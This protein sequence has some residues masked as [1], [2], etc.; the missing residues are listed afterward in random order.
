MCTSSRSGLASVTATPR[1]VG[2]GVWQPPELFPFDLAQFLRQPESLLVPDTHSV[3]R[4]DAENMW[5]ESFALRSPILD[6]AL[7]AG[8]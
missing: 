7:S 6:I 5:S 3:D 4:K 2:N 1:F 8:K